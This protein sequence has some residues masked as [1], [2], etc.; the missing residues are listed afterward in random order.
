M[1]QAP[2]HD[3]HNE[4]ETALNLSKKNQPPG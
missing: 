4:M 2:G 1:Q 3:K